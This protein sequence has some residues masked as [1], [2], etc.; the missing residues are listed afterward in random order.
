ME[1]LKTISNTRDEDKVKLWKNIWKQ[2]LINGQTKNDKVTIQIP[3]FLDENN[4]PVEIQYVIGDLEKLLLKKPCKVAN[5]MEKFDKRKRR[6]CN[7]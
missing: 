4:K 7:S 5:K 3:R 1:F 2:A 6:H